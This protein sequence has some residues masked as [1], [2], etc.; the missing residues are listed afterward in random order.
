MECVDDR[1]IAFIGSAYFLGWM[2]SSPIWLRLADVWGR[3]LL[4]HVSIIPHLILTAAFFLITPSNANWLIIF[5]NVMIGLKESMTSIVAYVL[6]SEMV[7]SKYRAYYSAANNI[8]DGLQNIL[9]SVMFYFGRDWHYVSYYYLAVL[10]LLF[11]VLFLV[12]ESPRYLLSKKKYERARAVYA[13]IA[14]INKREMFTE[15]LEGEAEPEGSHQRHSISSDDSASARGYYTHHKVEG[16]KYGSMKAFFKAGCALW[17]PLSLL[18][19]MW[20]TVNIV[21]YGIQIGTKD[22]KGNMLATTSLSACADMIGY[23]LAGFGANYLGRK[24]SLFLGFT[25]AAIACLIYSLFHPA[26]W[27]VY[28]SVALGK[29]G[30]SFC[31]NVIY[32]VTAETYSTEYRGTV[33]GAANFFA[34]GGGFLAPIVE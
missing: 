19:I 6:L 21:F 27:A 31:F 13:K 4:I 25:L 16:L 14:R 18:L 17:F 22:F 33:F 15:P 20:I 10:V 5:I 3:R 11:F 32:I 34:R 9:I 7:S 23:T 29:L 24:P 28:L 2:I 26:T 30:I 1:I 12:P 8:Y